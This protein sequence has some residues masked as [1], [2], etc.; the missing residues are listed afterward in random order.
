[1]AT[2]LSSSDD[3][4]LAK[5]IRRYN[6]LLVPW[7]IWSAEY[8]ELADYVLPRK[9]SIQVK[10][11]PGTKRT[12]KLFDSTA[13]RAS[14][15]L[16]SSMH[17]SLTSSNLRWFYLETDDQEL[18]QVDEVRVW[19]YQVTERM[20][21]EFNRSNF[22]SEIH[23]CYL[24]L[25]VF[26]TACM[27]EDTALSKEKGFPGLEFQSV[28]CGRYVIGEGPDGR[29]NTVFRAFS[30]SGESI[31]LKWPDRASDI[32]SLEA[33]PDQPRT[34]IQGVYPATNNGAPLLNKWDSSW[35]LAQE[36]ISL[37]R[38]GFKEFPFMC[39]RWSKVNGET[40]GRGPSHVA[41]PD[42]RSLNKVTELELKALA[43]VVDPPVMVLAGDAIGPVRLQPGAPTTVRSMESVK[44]LML[45]IDFKVSNLKSEQL[46]TSIREMFYSDQL[47]MP[48]GPQMTAEEVRVRYELMQRIMGPALGRLESELLKPMIDRTFAIGMR[49]NIFPPIPGAIQSAQQQGKVTLKIRYEGPLA[50]AQKAAD[51][52]S[53]QQLL[54]MAEPLMQID[55]KV[56]DVINFDEVMRQTAMLTGVPPSI[57][58][59]EDDTQA[60]R[61]EQQQQQQAQQGPEQSEQVAGAASKAA[62]LLTALNKAPEPGSPAAKVA[63]MR[64]GGA[65]GPSGAAAA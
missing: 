51:V 59:D 26:G 30:M 28:P 19:L 2:N 38:S 6:E 63:A 15:M 5:D 55:P 56:G 44:P 29:A 61:D 3:D 32:V 11:T 7:R 40:Y 12:Q 23:E 65:G 27:F 13:V 25:V 17:G 16:A 50:R 46:K 64:G 24:D 10:R 54:Q 42:I 20:I 1:M 8:Q 43:K 39:P 18:N 4:Q 34:V 41:L 62:P 57:V 45:G 52:S 22:A 31:K 9:N 14:E 36:R 21:W 37:D 49:Y 53:I 48:Q 60:Y 35:F 47:Q 33:R 58:R